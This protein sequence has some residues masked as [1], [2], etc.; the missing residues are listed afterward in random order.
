[1]SIN[2]FLSCL[3][4]TPPPPH[5]FN[6]YNHHT[7]ANRTR[8]QNLICYLRRMQQLHPTILLVGEAPGYRGCRLTGVPFTSQTILQEGIAPFLLFGANNGYQT[9]TEWP[10]IQREATSTI[11]WQAISTLIHPPLLWNATP[12]HPHQPG[13]PQSNRTPTISELDQGRPF[14]TH[15][16]HNFNINRIIAVGNKADQALTRQ[17]IPH[18]KIRHPSHGGKQA[19]IQGL[20]EACQK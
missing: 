5:C 2:E 3:E 7:A 10:H 18:S 8:R 4:N 14:L 20:I 17:K 6:P 9:T 15:L 1:M 11:M 19:F 12:F 16:L 13:N